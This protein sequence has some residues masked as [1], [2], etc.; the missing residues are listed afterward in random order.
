MKRCERV[1]GRAGK[2]TKRTSGLS[3]V[4]LDLEDLDDTVLGDE[5]EALGARGAEETGG[6]EDEAEGCSQRRRGQLE[7]VR[8]GLSQDV[9]VVKAPVSSAMKR[10]LVPSAVERCS[11]VSV[12]QGRRGGDPD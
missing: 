11:A 5:S 4:G 10:T 2:E 1:A 6:V 12:R 3:R 7:R 8:D 9:Q